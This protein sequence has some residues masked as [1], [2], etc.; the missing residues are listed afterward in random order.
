MIEFLLL[1]TAIL[2]GFIGSL[3]GLGGGV[4]L[5]P[6]LTLGFG[7]HIRYAIAA[8]L[9]SI[10]VTSLIA[11]RRF[12]AEGLANLR[13]AIFL[14][15]ATVAGALSGFLI[16]NLLEA[17]TLTLLFGFFMLFSAALV[18]RRREEQ[19]AVV[20]HPWVEKLGLSGSYAIAG[21]P[22]G[23]AILFLAGVLSALLGIGSGI[24]KVLAMDG[25]MKL[26]LKVS[27]ATSNLMIGVTAAASTG[28]FL[29]RGDVIPE[30]A[31]PISLG[32]LVGAAA[33]AKAMVRMPAQRIRKIFV[34]VLV[35]AATQMIWRGFHA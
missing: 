27:S 9:L 19:E 2:A 26:P 21:L 34:V 24:F 5:V 6:A 23:W 17:A 10:I 4:V 35:L 22:L 31:G 13:L 11:S 32:V 14:E 12:L 29:A 25:V 28:A 16:A 15:T 20:S 7:I 1:C 18:A 30:I 8:S 33:G 3:L